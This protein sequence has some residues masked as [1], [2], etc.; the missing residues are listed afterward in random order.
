[1]RSITD[2]ALRRS[3]ALDGV[4]GPCRGLALG[5]LVLGCSAGGDGIERGP[6]LG[7]EASETPVLDFSARGGDAEGDEVLHVVYRDFKETHP[8]FEMEFRGDVVRRKLVD[9]VLGADQKPVFVS[10][11]G[12]PWDET[13]PVNCA[14]WEVATPVLSTK[15]NFEQW[16]H[17]VPDVNLRIEG[18]LGLFTDGSGRHIYSSDAFFPLGPDEGFKETPRGHYLGQ[19]FLFTTEIHV[20]FTYVE[21]QTFSFFGDDDL[22]IFVN[23]TLALDLGSM[24]AKALGTIDFDAQAAAL[25]ITPGNSYAMDVFHAERHTDGSNFRIETN[26]SGFVP[27]MVR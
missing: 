22:W 23:G 14:N 6:G 1:M 27:V 3:W 20:T 19:N 5:V 21:G 13:S 8:D 15:E 10:P 4:H 18:T 25:G 26:I 7:G 9:S 16:Y 12:C 17:D 2:R 11:I 24:H